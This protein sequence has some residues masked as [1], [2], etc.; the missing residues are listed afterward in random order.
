MKKLKRNIISKNII[1]MLLSLLI[2]FL[3][4]AS[5]H[6]FSQKINLEVGQISPENYFAPFQVEN[7]IA[8]EKKRQVAEQAIPDVFVINSVVLEETITNIGLLFESIKDN[9]ELLVSN[10][11]MLASQVI[12]PL[13]ENIVTETI[14]DKDKSY[15][16]TSSQKEEL[17]IIQSLKL[18]SSVVLTDEVYRILLGMSDDRLNNLKENILIMS[19][20]ILEEGISIEDNISIK[21]R[22]QLEISNLSTLEETIAYEIMLSQLKPNIVADEASTEI[23]KKKAR[24]QVEPVYILKG[25]RIVAEGTRVTDESYAILKKV[26]YINT[27]KTFSLDQYIGVFL[28]VSIIG[29]LFVYY[30]RSRKSMMLLTDKEYVFI[31]IT[32]LI[33][34]FIMFMFKNVSSVFL[35]LSFGSVLVAVLIRKDLAVIMHIILV[36]VGSMICMDDPM[37]LSYTILTGLLSIF[38]V[39]DLKNRKQTMINAF[40]VGVMFSVVYVSITLSKSMPLEAET[41]INAV[42]VF[43]LGVM[44]VIVIVGSLPLWEALFGF[45][46]PI[47]LLELTN[48]NQPLLKKLLIEATGTYYHSLLIAN[49]AETAA[50]EIG[51]NPLLARVGG[52][53]HDIGKLKNSNYFKENQVINNPHDNLDPKESAAYILAHVK[54]GVETAKEYN[55]PKSV[56]DIIQQHHGD[57]MVQYFYVKEKEKGSII[58]EKD[59]RYSGPKPQTKEAALI[60]LADVVEATVR[61]MQ[62]KIEKDTVIEDIVRKIIKQKL[63][64]GELN[65]SSLYISDIETIISSFSKMLK[66]MYHERI[67]YPEIDSES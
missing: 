64:N 65:D 1:L 29:V 40:W 9:N 8:T 7:E 51:A 60:M 21:I 57:S 11:D 5:T 24:E 45:V 19:Q 61:S 14:E 3:L 44:Q 66:G 17:S 49:L 43:L 23:E 59:F 50:N 58:D 10:K 34:L 56:I 39:G 31:F 32:Y 30:I 28:L 54:A 22:E 67:E 53:Y 20:N 33:S 37:F 12:K 63:D 2:T 35:P 47:Q 15:S 41:I 25:E 36:L 42:E 13:K 4:I 46:T 48:P 26:G 38:I 55:L 27:E 16:S 62:T 6:I 52:Y 18:K